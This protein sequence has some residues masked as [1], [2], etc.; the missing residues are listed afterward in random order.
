MNAEHL[1]NRRKEIGRSC[2]I[3]KII[4]V[5]YCAAVKKRKTRSSSGLS[6]SA[7]YSSISFNKKTPQTYIKNLSLHENNSNFSASR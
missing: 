7:T 3:H 6:N 4:A 1:N 5:F 2:A